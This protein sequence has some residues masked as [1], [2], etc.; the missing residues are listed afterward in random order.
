MS[1][2][3]EFLED[4][5][6]Q[7]PRRIEE[8]LDVRREVARALAP[9]DGRSRIE[10]RLK[11]PTSTWRKMMRYGLAHDEV[12]DLIGL[13]VIV[14][15][16]EQCYEA[17]ELLREGLPGIWDRFKDYIARPK[18]NGYQ[19]LHI[20]ARLH[21]GPIFEIQIRTRAMHRRCTTGVAAHDRYKRLGAGDLAPSRSL[22]R[23]RVDM[24]S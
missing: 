18:S 16:V 1:R 12:H 20:C 21:S 14:G 8:I 22:A 10:A 24:A 15:R 17:L 2:Y 4:Y 3:L 13:R 23:T 7:E 9:L 19:S 5:H 11:S 6:R